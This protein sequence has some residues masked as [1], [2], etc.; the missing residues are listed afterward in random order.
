V[1]EVI[2]NGIGMP[3]EPLATGTERGIGLRNVNER[4]QVIYG[5]TCRLKIRSAAGQG[6]SVQLDIPDLVIPERVSA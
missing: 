2:D 6:T 5:A 4:L 1:I 3:D